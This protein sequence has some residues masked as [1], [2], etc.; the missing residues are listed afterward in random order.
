MNV[1]AEI[2]RGAMRASLGWN[3]TENEIS[4]FL[5]IWERVYANL[6]RGKSARAA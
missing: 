1:P 5:E 6:R 4:R 2:A 3:T